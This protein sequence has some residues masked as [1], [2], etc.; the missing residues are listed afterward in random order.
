MLERDGTRVR[1][2]VEPAAQ[3]M[4]CVAGVA[5]LPGQPTVLD[6]FRAE[7]AEL[8]GKDVVGRVERRAAAPRRV[9]YP[10]SDTPGKIAVVEGPSSR[11]R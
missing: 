4:G 2:T 1:V 5:E 10:S 6:A 8:C 11:G 3:R 7:I 9:A